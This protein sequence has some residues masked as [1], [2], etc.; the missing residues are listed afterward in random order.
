[1]GGDS[2]P[3]PLYTPR[4]FGVLRGK[5]PPYDG[6]LTLRRG[7]ME[8]IVDPDLVKKFDVD[9]RGRITLGKDEFGGSRVR[10]AVEKLDKQ[11]PQ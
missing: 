2:N 11:E 5:P 10:V 7:D 1:M 6:E 9:D 3:I 8:T 4:P